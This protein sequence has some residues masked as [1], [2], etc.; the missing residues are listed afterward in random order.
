MHVANPIYD[1]AFK[2]LLEDSKVAKLL[3]SAIIGEDILELEFSAQ[4]HIVEV[5]P[6]I[7]EKTPLTV[8]R[9]DFS[10]KIKTDTG[11]KTVI[12]ELQKAKL[13]SDI[14]RFR[15]YLG[16]QYQNPGNSYDDKQEKARQIYCIYF[17]DY[18]MDLPPSPVL[19]VN[20]KLWDAYTGDE[21]PASGEFVSGLHHL[22]WIVQIQHLKE[23]R[24]NEMEKIL[25]IFDQSSITDSK[26]V[27]DVDEDLFPDEYRQI[28]RRLRKAMEDPQKRREMELEDD[29]IKELQDKERQIEAKDK[30]LEAKDKALEAKDKALE[31]KDKALEE[32]DQIIAELEKKIV[33]MGLKN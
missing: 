33:E 8:C 15:R 19:R 9:I 22:S 24:R 25:S 27:L 32:K 21:Y 23:R 30:A 10:A 2:Y 26:Y 14:M 11:F 5:N 28:I 29:V 20:Y 12:I 1:V 6:L 3:L 13:Q 4:E 31:E 18:G 17:L 16:L 7:K